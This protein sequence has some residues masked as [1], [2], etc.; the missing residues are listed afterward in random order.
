[1]TIID[2]IT[3]IVGPRIFSHMSA[4]VIHGICQSPR[5]ADSIFPRTTEQVSAIMKPAFRIGSCG[6]MGAYQHN[7]GCSSVRG[8]CSIL[9]EQG[10]GDQQ[11]LLPASNRGHLHAA[12][13]LWPRRAYVPP[14]PQRDHRILG[15]VRRASKHRAVKMAPPRLYQRPQGGSGRRDHY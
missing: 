14:N 7:R 9:H 15:M 13:Y 1:M 8:L 12:Q 6:A 11:R 4:S 3:Q 2:E 10:T 5:F